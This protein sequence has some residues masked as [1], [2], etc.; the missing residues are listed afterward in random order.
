MGYLKKIVATE[1]LVFDFELFIC[2]RFDFLHDIKA[3][4]IN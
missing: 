1:L 2:D 4:F 3:F